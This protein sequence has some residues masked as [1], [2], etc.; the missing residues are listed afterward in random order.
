MF[1]NDA[2]FQKKLKRLQARGERYKQ[3]YEVKSA[4]A[5]YVPERKKKKVSTIVLVIAILAIVLYTVANFW[6]AYKTGL[7]MDA[8]L[9]T[10]FYA[11]WGSELLLLA[12]IKTS[13]IIKGS[14]NACG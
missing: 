6:L 14:D 1:M 11:F 2:K 12:G 8:T 10:C 13:K 7:Y 9:T 5:E 3:E 4:Y